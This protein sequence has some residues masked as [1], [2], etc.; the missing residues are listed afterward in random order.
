VA[1]YKLEARGRIRV[2]SDCYARAARA[3]V[4][5]ACTA[6]ASLTVT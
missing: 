4:P 5:C 2:R 1:W 6:L 3:S